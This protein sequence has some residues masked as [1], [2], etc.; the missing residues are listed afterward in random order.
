MPTPHISADKGDF[1]DTILLPG[2]PLRAKHIAEN[3]LDNARLVNEVRG[4]LGYTGEYKGTPVSVMGT[5]MGIPSASIYCT[6]LVREYGVEN[7]IRVGTCGAMQPDIAVR[8]IILGMGACTNSGVNRFRFGGDD[9]AAI[10]DF[11]LLRTAV[12]TAERLGMSVHVGNLFSGDLFYVRDPEAAFGRI[13]AMGVLGAEM[14]A[15]GIYGV[16]AET[17]AKALAIVMVSD[18]LLTHEAL[19]SEERQTAVDEMV[20]LTLETVIAL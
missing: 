14:E 13:A 19:S 9:F 8:D 10:A 7:L 15:A 3:H 6:E 4:M 17:G 11:H 2:D 20:E 18:H 5:G 16:A 1:A 12:E